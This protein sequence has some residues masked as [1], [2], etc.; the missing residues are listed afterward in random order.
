LAARGF[1][2][3]HSLCHG[4]LGNLEVLLQLAGR[5]GVDAWR[6]LSLQHATRVAREVLDRRW[7]CGLPRHAETPGL[8]LGTAGIG[9]GLLSLAHPGRVPSALSLDGPPTPAAPLR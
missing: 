2:G 8:M 5:F 3:N 4:D 1:G 9:W 7:L 6:E